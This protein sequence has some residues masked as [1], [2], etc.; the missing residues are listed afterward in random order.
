MTKTGRLFDFPQLANQI[1]N[2]LSAI[3]CL[4]WK[5][6]KK[7]A[8]GDSCKYMHKVATMIIENKV[9]EVPQKLKIL[10]KVSKEYKKEM[11]RKN[12]LGDCRYGEA[13]QDAHSFEEKRREDECFMTYL[14]RLELD[15]FDYIVPDRV[16]QRQKLMKP[17]AKRPFQKKQFKYQMKETNRTKTDGTTEI[18][19]DYSQLNNEAIGVTSVCQETFMTVPS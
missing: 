18:Q 4:S 17:P 10:V 1:P 11:C 19:T 12:K 2:S 7:C 3:E 16:L 15:V 6:D 14:D 5:R 13:C 9:V 8:K